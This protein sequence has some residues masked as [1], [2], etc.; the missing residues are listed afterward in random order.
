MGGTDAAAVAAQ[1]ARSKTLKELAPL[2]DAYEKY[3][4]VR[5]A[6]ID[7]DPMLDD[8]DPS[9]REMFESEHD[10]LLE[11]LD[12]ALDLLPDLLLPP[13]ETAHLPAIMTLNA[14]V[15]GS[16]AALFVE[17]MSRTYQRF[18]EKRGWKTEIMSSSEGAGSKGGGGLRE[19][20]MKFEPPPYG[21]EDSELYGLVKWERG[22]HR[23]QRIPQTETQGRV[24]TSTIAAIVSEP[25]C[26]YLTPRSCPSIPTCLK[27]RS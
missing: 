12:A 9:L 23:V 16:E 7:V 24:H 21:G 22:V 11:E 6:L 3:T 4:G 1:I 5:Q 10:S 25:S 14:G 13:S 8:P 27:P 26:L 17:E 15:G 18:A 2:A 20:T 19:I